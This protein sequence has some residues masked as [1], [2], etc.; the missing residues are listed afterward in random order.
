MS[1]TS[2]RVASESPRPPRTGSL[3]TAGGNVT[4][5]ALLAAKWL[6]NAGAHDEIR[7]EMQHAIYDPT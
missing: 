3:P 6:G 7:E 5:N 2:P 1:K 4:A